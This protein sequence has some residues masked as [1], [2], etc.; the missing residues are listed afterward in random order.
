MIGRA[1]RSGRCYGERLSRGSGRSFL[2]LL[3]ANLTPRRPTLRWVPR[4]LKGKGENSQEDLGFSP[5][6]P[7]GK[8]VGGLGLGRALP[9]N[10]SP[11]KPGEGRQ[12]KTRPSCPGHGK[13]GPGNNGDVCA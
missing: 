4:S 13:T 10:P 9:P 1:K 2:S 12:R 8:G 3:S 7:L 5:P 6:S 11:P